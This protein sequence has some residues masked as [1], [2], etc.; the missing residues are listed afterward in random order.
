MLAILAILAI[1][2][3]GVSHPP[4]L[5]NILY[6]EYRM[7]DIFDNLDNNFVSYGKKKIHTIID[8]N[9]EI[10]FN[11]R[12]I[13]S[14]LRYKDSKNAIGAH[15]DSEDTIQLKYIQYD[16][17]NNNHTKHP[18]SK[19][20]NESGLWSLLISSKM[21]E[22]KKFRRWITHCVLPSIRKY[23]YYKLKKNTDNEINLLTKQINYLVAENEKIKKDNR[24]KNFPKGGIVYAIDY[25]DEYNKIYRIGMT[26]DMT[27][28][29]K[30]YDT[31]TLH[32]HDVVFIKETK[33][34]IRLESCL[35][36]M[37]Y[38]YRFDNKKDYYVCPLNKIKLSMDKCVKS[39]GCIDKQSGGSTVIS[40]E[41]KLLNDKYHKLKQKSIRLDKIIKSNK[42]I[43]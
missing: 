39:M 37:L 27:K 31:H 40:N 32:N 15:V 18:N 33:C 9:N 21:P 41:L 29:K 38:N 35:K 17:I 13:T 26:G 24:K 8:F 6:K 3:R 1:I 20:L 25:S 16:E 14:S 2:R 28:R 30:I 19:Y 4:I 10:W 11:A 7:L 12:D 23:G 5:Y 34:P 43:L 36:S 22:T 42:T